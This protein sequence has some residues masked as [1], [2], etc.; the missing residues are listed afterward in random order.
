MGYDVKLIANE[1]ARKQVK[2]VE[3]YHG[4]PKFRYVPGF[5]PV[6]VLIF[7]DNVMNVAFG[8]RPV[9]VITTSK[10]ISE[11]YRKFFY[12]MWKIAKK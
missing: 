8:E 9:A 4:H 10:L 3:Y 11:S 6:G 5:A 12:N 2:T 1:S 7:G